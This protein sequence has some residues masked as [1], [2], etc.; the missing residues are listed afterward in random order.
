MSF[1]ELGFRVI[2]L[3]LRKDGH[4]PH[5]KHYTILHKSYIILTFQMAER[6][7]TKRVP[8]IAGTL[9]LWPNG[10][11]TLCLMTVVSDGFIAIQGKAVACMAVVIF[12][13]HTHCVCRA[14]RARLAFAARREGG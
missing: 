6:Q 12:L 4:L 10:S 5:Q 3:S 11:A 8:A 2:E 7:Q 1:I 13:A 9:T 14:F